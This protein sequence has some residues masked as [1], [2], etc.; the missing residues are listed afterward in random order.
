[1]LFLFPQRHLFNWKRASLS[2]V[3][4]TEWCFFF[5]FNVISCKEMPTGWLWYKEELGWGGRGSFLYSARQ[6]CAANGL[7][8]PPQCEIEFLNISKYLCKICQFRIHCNIVFAFV[9]PSQSLLYSLTNLWEIF[10]WRIKGEKAGIHGRK[11]AMGHFWP[12]FAC[13]KLGYA[14]AT[15]VGSKNRVVLRRIIRHQF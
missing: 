12:R 7:H 11:V 5:Y 14:C 10:W 4:S 8:G 15:R 2:T 1:M 3:V 6:M 13:P 9:Y